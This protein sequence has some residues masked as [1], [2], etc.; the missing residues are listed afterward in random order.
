MNSIAKARQYLI[1]LL[2][3]Y[4]LGLSCAH[5]AEQHDFSSV[6]SHEEKRRQIIALEAQRLQAFRDSNVHTLKSMLGKDYYHV[7]SNGRLRS[8]TEFL[9]SL[10]RGEFVDVDQTVAASEMDIKGA[11]AI[12]RGEVRVEHKSVF[13]ERY[14]LRYVRVWQHVG[15]RWVNTMHQTTRVRTLHDGPN[16]TKL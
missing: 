4:C 16:Q 5:S 6:S 12:V 9:Q 1:G 10:Q 15:G 2:A 8:K 14:I 7:D 3:C 13:I 11:V